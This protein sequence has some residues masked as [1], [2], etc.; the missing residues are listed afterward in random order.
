MQVD[1][2]S[3][4]F[5]AH[6]A[7]TDKDR[8][9][10]ADL[11]QALTSLG[12]EQ[13]RRLFRTV[14]EIEEPAT[15]AQL[16]FYVPSVLHSAIQDRVK[17]LTP[18]SS[19][20]LSML[21]AEQARIEHLLDAGLADV[22]SVFIEAESKLETLGK[23]PGRSLQRLRFRLRLLLLREK[24]AELD[25]VSL[26][27]D[28]AEL[29]KAAAQDAIDFFRALSKLRRRD[30]DV[31][32]AIA[33]FERLHTRHRDIPAYYVNL[34][35]SR[36]SAI[37]G[38]D[39]FGYVKQ[40]QLAMARTISTD[41]QKWISET[42]GYTEKD[43]TTVLL[44]SALL[45]LAIK[46]PRQALS[47]LQT[48]DA[49][50]PLET[51]FAYRALALDRSGEPA[52]AQATLVEAESKFGKTPLI[53]ATAK[54]IS[55]GSPF[56]GPVASVSHEDSVLWI[57][58]AHAHLHL[59][60]ATDQARALSPDD[61]TIGE[62]LLRH[63]RE[64]SSG[65]TQLV[66]MMRNLGLSSLEDDVTAVL[67]EILNARLRIVNWALGDQSKGGFTAEANPGERDL[68][69]TRDTAT[70]TIVEAVMVRR[71][72]TH[73]DVRDDLTLHFVKL[74]GYGNCQVYFHVTYVM[75]SEIPGV[76]EH[77]KAVARENPPAGIE[78]LKAEDLPFSDSGP[79]GFSAT[80]RSDS[81]ERQVH[82]LVLDLNQGL[83]KNAAKA[84]Q[85]LKPKPA[86]GAA[87]KKRKKGGQ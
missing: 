51:L 66:P 15:L 72:M 3:A 83:E 34:H 78:Y 42:R 35:A 70:L 29:D 48:I 23:V 4:S 52:L 57:R 22:A 24:W 61:S 33:I 44:N 56:I 87:K 21:A 55:L 49:D 8:P 38:E 47:L 54:Q 74:F 79:R 18:E 11:G 67:K 40:D 37:L 60:N 81:G 80:Y 86:E 32:D 39:K 28:D 84:A 50:R 65:V 20:D 58:R 63:I 5:D 7:W 59:L 6:L 25:K 9:I 62:F 45:S 82:F 16:L 76:L 41:G 2:F 13:Q 64:A 10:S 17:G 85:S 30:S 68:V 77:L 53:E 36:V 69:I 19:S 12:E 71:P 73:A 14:L 46:Q 27:E 26:P 43:K 75:T 1:A 31:S